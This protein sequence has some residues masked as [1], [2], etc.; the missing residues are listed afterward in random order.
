MADTK[1][2]AFTAGT[3]MDSANLSG[4]QGGVNK[5]FPTTLF[6][7]AKVNLA[8]AVAPGATDDSA[9]GYSVGSI[10]VDTTADKSYLCVDSTATAAVWNDISAGGGDMILADVQT[11]TGAKTFDDTKFFLR[12]VADTFSASFVNTITADRIYTLPDSAGTIALTTTAPAAH[13]ASHT[14]GSD[15]I[16]DATAAQKG[17][18]TATQITKLDGI[19]ALAD[20]TDAANVTTALGTVSVD[21]HS[22]VVSATN[23]NR[24]VLVANGTT[25]YVGRALLEADISDLQTYAVSGGAFHDGFSDFV[26]GEHFLQ[27]AITEVGTVTTGNV[28]AVVSA[29]S[30][31]TAGKIEIATVAETN[32]G[33]DATRAVSPDGLDGWTGSVQVV[34]LGTVTTGNVD[35]VVSAADLTTAG[36]VELATVAET[37]TGTD[38]T[39]AVTPD[40]LDGWTGSAQVAT[41]G[42]VTTGNVDAVVSASDETTAGKIEI[43]TQAEVD[44]GTDDTRAITPAKLFHSSGNYKAVNAQTGTTY[45]AVAS[46][47]GKLIT[48]DNASANTLSI[49]DS[50]F[51]AGDVVYVMQK[52]AGA[53]TIA[54]TASNNVVSDK[55]LVLAGQWAFAAI[56]I[57]AGGATTVSVVT[58]DLTAS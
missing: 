33:T 11:V 31:T 13:A 40:G 8:A 23:T 34:T 39:R 56:Y 22:D 3:D 44:T 2:S 43:A 45:T 30:L 55:T 51:A 37:N 10:W 42:T 27:S 24:F 17:L 41:V 21:A 18:A 6:L 25:G 38:A 26:A 7:S 35:A 54:G 28:D 47:A 46:D 53:T 14:D 19:E 52:G 5:R 9:S 50:V 29:A 15:D 20:V 36:K 1:I 49:N 16:Q 4:I 48:M 58:G 32:T 12:N 57:D